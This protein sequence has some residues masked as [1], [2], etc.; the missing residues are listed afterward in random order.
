MLSLGSE[1]RPRHM[2]HLHGPTEP[3]AGKR[4]TKVTE[5]RTKID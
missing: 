2:Q 5:L 1:V 4:I 3:L